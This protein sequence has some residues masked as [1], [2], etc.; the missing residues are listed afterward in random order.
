MGRLQGQG[1][2]TTPAQDP[3][4]PLRLLLCCGPSRW[5]RHAH[6]GW[7]TD[8]RALGAGVCSWAVPAAVSVDTWY[9]WKATLLD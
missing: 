7:V 6:H 8:M 4:Q 2:L 9:T 1:R 5:R 3:H